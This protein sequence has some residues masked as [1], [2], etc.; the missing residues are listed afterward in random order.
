[1]TFLSEHNLSRE[2]LKVPLSQRGRSSVEFLG[3]LQ[4]YS[5]GVLRPKARAEFA[6]DPEGAR[7]NALARDGR[8]NAPWPEQVNAARAVAEKSTSYRFERFYQRVVAEEQWI[9]TIQAVEERRPAF[10]AFLKAPAHDVGGTLELDPDLAMPDYYKGMEWHLEPGGWEGYDLYGPL[11][12]VVA[13]PL[14]FRYGGYAAVEHGDNI[15]QQRVN[16]LKQLPKSSYAHIYEPGC[17][18]V[19]TLACAREVFP[20]AE[21]HGSDLS[22]QLL[23]MGHLTANRLGIPVHFKQRDARATRE[24][25]ASVD[26]VVMYALMHEM[27]PEVAVDTFKEAIRILKPGGDLI[28]GDPPPFA[29]VEPFQSVI[30]DWETEHRAEPFF[31]AACEQ[32]WGRSLADIGFVDVRSYGMGRHAYP[33]VNRAVKPA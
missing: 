12:A 6:A 27:P 25:D 32:D 20:G 15:V 2:R 30:L 3:A 19:S 10:E 16:F 11:F 23:E 14:I 18:G 4:N 5:S 24:P 13:G 29:A 31:T 7:L 9:R 33:Y 26:A 21:L 22:R 17:G 8:S 1:M 28:V